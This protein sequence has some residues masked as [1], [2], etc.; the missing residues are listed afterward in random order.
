VEAALRAIVIARFVKEEEEKEEFELGVFVGSRGRIESHLSLSGA[1]GQR[2][3]RTAS[4]RV[5]QRRATR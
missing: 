1:A 2:N 5:N 3:L 4:A